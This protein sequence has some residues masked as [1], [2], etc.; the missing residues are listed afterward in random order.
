MNDFRLPDDFY[1]VSLTDHY[2]RLE[3]AELARQLQS[4]SPLSEF[5]VIWRRLNMRREERK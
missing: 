2:H 5:P 3:A 1:R 4:D